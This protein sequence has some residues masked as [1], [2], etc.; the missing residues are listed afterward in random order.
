[1][2]FQSCTVFGFENS[3]FRFF[4]ICFGPR[5]RFRASNFEL[6]FFYSGNPLSMY[7]AAIAGLGLPKA[8]NQRS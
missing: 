7:I 4:Y 8:P 3:P 2:H 1:M 5:G 6:V